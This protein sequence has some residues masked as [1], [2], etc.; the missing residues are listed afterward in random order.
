MCVQKYKLGSSSLC[1]FLQP[2]VIF[3]GGGSQY[4]P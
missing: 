2:A 1:S 3:L 4:V